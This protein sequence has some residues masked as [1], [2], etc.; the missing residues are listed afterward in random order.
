MDGT[1]SNGLDPARGV[2]DVGWLANRDGSVSGT[3]GVSGE[4]GGGGG[5][6]RS[7]EAVGVGG[8]VT[9]EL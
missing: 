2:V 3:G 5:E 7:H 4:E 6:M 8:K 9:V 1:S